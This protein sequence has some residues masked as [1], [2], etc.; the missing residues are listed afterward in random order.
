MIDT[1]LL[2]QKILDLA[3]RG[4]LV[5]QDPNDEPA[6][7]LLERIRA[8]REKLVAEGK[9]KRSKTTTDNR[10]YENVP[11]EIPESWEWVQLGFIS[12]YGQIIHTAVDAIQPDEWVL[13]LE[14]IEKE[15][16]QVLQI[17]S[18]RERDLSGVRNKFSQSQVLYSKLRTYLNKVLV[19]PNAGYCTTEIMPFSLYCC[20]DAQ[21]ICHVIRSKYFIDYTTLCCY[22]CKMPRLSTDDAQ[23]GLIPLPPIAEQK[24][25][26]AEIKRL[27]LLIDDVDISKRY[28]QDTIQQTKYKILDLAIHGKLV[29]QDPNDEPASD[30]FKR[31]APNVTLCDNSHYENLPQSWCVTTLGDVGKWQSGGTPKRDI[32]DFYGGDV[33]WLKTG[34]LNDS[35]ITSIPEYITQAGVENS[36]A[37]VNPQGSV[38]VAM[39][40]ATIGK[41]GIL[42]FPAATNQACCAC[43]D[44]PA[45]D[46]MYLYYF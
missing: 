2:K 32:K 17:K 37:K 42:T 33:P 22:G 28:L 36:S 41:I 45:L 12:S 35:F 4:K 27:F 21:Y 40:G 7:V 19:A 30:L 5:P 43:I 9:L 26:V 11:F 13:E 18:R 20:I 44:Y 10:H 6:S 23:K 24:R 46:M 16:A 31:I 15:S 39:Y 8:E 25:I 3:I 1:K 34:D 29:S 38:L 14:D